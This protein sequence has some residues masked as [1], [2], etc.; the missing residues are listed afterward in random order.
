MSPHEPSSMDARERVRDL[1]IHLNGAALRAVAPDG[2]VLRHLAR[3]GHRLMLLGE[4][5]DRDGWS[6]DLRDVRRVVVLGAGKGA[7]P[8]ALA[9]EEL[10]GGRVDDGLVIVKYGHDLPP[11][12]RT[13]HVRVLEGAHPVPDEAGM[14]A[15]ARLADMA[16]ACGPDD[17]ALCVFTG[18]ASALTPAL[19]PDISLQDL[20]QLTRLLLECG[21]S[22]HEINCLRK[23]LSRLSGGSLARSLAPA[24]VLGL[25]VS[26]VVGDDLDVIASGPTVPDSSTFADCRDI[27]ARYGLD[28]RLPAAIARHLALGLQGVVPDTPKAGDPAFARLRNVLVA[29]LGQALQAAADEAGRQG[30]RPVLLT[31]SLT[32]E[33]RV[34]ARELVERARV[35]QRELTPGDRPLCLLAGGETT[36]T[37]RGRGRGGRNQEMALAASLE[38]AHDQGIDALFAGTDGTDGP[39]DAAGGFAFSG[40]A[41]T[42]PALGVDARAMLDDNDSYDCLERCGTLYRS[43]P[44]RTNVMDA[45]IILVRPR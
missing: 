34:R 23:H 38:L 24:R 13:R 15:A 22:I 21:A 20:Q 45:A 16:A 3:D 40:D 44:T 12:S 25:I 43:G 10:L 7:A 28:G 4:P 42:W 19:Q 8:M 39:T 30:L 37:I 6:A 36:V 14:H 26:D 5:A 32:G 33:A 11:D 9:V 2:A 17:L 27:V 41:L 1:L 35:L 31:D 29:T 18:G